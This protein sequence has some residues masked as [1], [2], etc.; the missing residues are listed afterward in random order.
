MTER[1]KSNK[2]ELYGLLKSLIR[3]LPKDHK[4][5][6]MAENVARKNGMVELVN[7]NGVLS[8]YCGGDA[9]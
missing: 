1:R 7:G 3:E 4:Y 9:G 8:E 2:R 5:K 6:Q